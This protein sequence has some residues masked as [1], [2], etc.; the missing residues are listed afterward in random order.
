MLPVFF[1][2]GMIVVL[3]CL[4]GSPVEV[5]V[6]PRFNPYLLSSGEALR[7]LK[8]GYFVVTTSECWVAGSLSR[9][10]KLAYF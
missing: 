10:S 3:T 9:S 5:K 2:S 8:L 1:D 4:I 6:L 7:S